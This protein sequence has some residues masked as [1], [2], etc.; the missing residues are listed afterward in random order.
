MGRLLTLAILVVG[1][2][3]QASGI[4]IDA[5]VDP[6]P[7]VPRLACTTGHEDKIKFDYPTSCGNDGSVEL[8]IPANDTAAMTAVAAISPAITCAAG[9]GRANCLASPGL[10]L[11]TYPTL[12][13]G[14]CLSSHGAM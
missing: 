8:C 4:R 2:G 5:S 11:C 3:D 9:G 14:Q 7:D 6:P 12:Y 10:L 1:C 13:P